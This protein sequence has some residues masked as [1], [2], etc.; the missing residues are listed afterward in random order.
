MKRIFAIAVAVMLAMGLAGCTGGDG[1]QQA[2]N[3]GSGA[4]IAAINASDLSGGV[5]AKVGDVEIGENAVTA[6]VNNFRYAQGLADDNAWGQWIYDNGYSPDAIRR[7]TVETL[8]SQELIR[9]GAAREGVLVTD[10][11]VEAKISEARGDASDED[12]AK[13]LDDQGLTD[14]F[15]RETVRVGLLQKGLSEKVAGADEADDETVLE[16]LKMYYPNDVDKDAK[17]L[18]GVDE[19]RV[20]LVRDL[21]KSFKGNTAFTEWMQSFRDEVGVTV[22]PTPEG[23]PYYVDLAP[24]EEAA[25]ADQGESAASDSSPAQADASSAAS[26]SAESSRAEDAEGE[27]E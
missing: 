25:N 8:V 12:Y 11:D 18:D 26:D 16:Y 20:Q 9:Q 1:S 24:F 21:V 3:V 22:N 27:N 6:Y 19:E 15:Y 4:Q 17:T 14:E 7:D 13:S 23:L 5:A 2:E 10:A